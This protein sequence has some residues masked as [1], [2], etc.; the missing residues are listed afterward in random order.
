[1]IFSKGERK[2]K[3][4][5]SDRWI[6]TDDVLGMV[7][8]QSFSALSFTIPEVRHIKHVD[9][10]KVKQQVIKLTDRVPSLWPRLFLGLLCQVFLDCK[11][12]AFEPSFRDTVSR[13]EKISREN[14]QNFDERKTMQNLFENLGI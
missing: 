1:M 11:V 10:N 2:K 8:M 13:E 9:S 12:Q 3:L 7:Y 4:S 14:L 6:L 5:K